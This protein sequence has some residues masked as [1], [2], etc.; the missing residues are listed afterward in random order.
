MEVNGIKQTVVIHNERGILLLQADQV[1]EMCQVMIMPAGCAVPF[2]D[3]V[4]GLRGEIWVTG[5]CS[6]G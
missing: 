6:V 2:N 1:T 3:P 4:N 5:G